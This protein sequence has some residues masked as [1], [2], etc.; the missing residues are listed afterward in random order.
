VVR[1]KESPKTYSLICR[2]N[3]RAKAKPLNMNNKNLTTPAADR[4]FRAFLHADSATGRSLVSASWRGINHKRPFAGL[5]TTVHMEAHHTRHFVS[6]FPE[7][8]N[9]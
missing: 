3:G 9:A 8:I 1:V 4:G 6:T 2:Q 7:E 5:G